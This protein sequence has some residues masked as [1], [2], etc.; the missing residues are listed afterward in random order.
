MRRTGLFTHPACLEHVTPPGHPER[1]ERLSAMLSELSAPEFAPL[2]RREAPRASRESLLRAHSTALV[3]HILGAEIGQSGFVRIDADTVM[4]KGSL[5]A[6]LRAA[7]GVIAAAD[8]VMANK[9]DNA[10]CA[11]RPPGHHAQH[12][13]AMGFCLFNNVAVAALHV[14]ATYGLRRVAVVDFDVHHGNGTQDIFFADADLFYASTHQFPLYPGTGSAAERGIASNIVNVPLPPGTGGGE[15]RHAFETRILPAL[16]SF[17]PEFIFVSAGFDAHG[18]D[19]LAS[20]R[21][22]EDDFAW[23]TQEICNVA[24]RVCSARVVSAL[25]GGYDLDA[26]RRSAAAHV[27]VLMQR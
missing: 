26:L 16:E 23:A 12:G 1:V 9:M 10:F 6:A 17:K 7:G 21:L 18:A 24:A 11:V 2:L 8:E 13:R 27:S 22:E 25:E 4:S 19:P 3:D 14:R 20:L 5:E 15:F